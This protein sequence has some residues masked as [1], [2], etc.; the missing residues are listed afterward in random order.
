MVG[1]AVT[2]RY[3][4]VREDLEKPVEFDNRTNKQR[5]AVES[6]EPGDVW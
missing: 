6:V 2:L 4:P 3:I 5:I 1:V